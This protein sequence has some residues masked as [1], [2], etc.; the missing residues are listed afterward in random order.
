MDE[1]QLIEEWMPSLRKLVNS[2]FRQ[3][4]DKDNLVGVGSVSLLMAVRSFD[5]SR[6][7]PFWKYA[8]KIIMRDL[9]RFVVSEPKFTTLPN[10]IL[11]GYAST[12]NAHRY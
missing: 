2:R 5:S 3:H 10:D 11:D 1:S 4:S 9:T 6:Q 7:I 12:G 8:R